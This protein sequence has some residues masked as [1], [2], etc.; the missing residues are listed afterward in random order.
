MISRLVVGHPLPLA[1]GSLKQI[2]IKGQFIVAQE[3]MPLRNIGAKVVGTSTSAISM[4]SSMQA[5]YSSYVTSKFALVKF[6]EVLAAEYPDIHV[7]TFHPGIGTVTLLNLQ[8]IQFG[9]DKCVVETDMFAKSEMSGLPMDTS[10]ISLTPLTHLAVVSTDHMLAALPAHFAVWLVSPEAAFLR[11]KF[12]ST[13]WDVDELKAR[14]K[15]VDSSLLLTSN[16]LGWPFQ[17]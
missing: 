4:D 16:I 5:N 12:V 2:N 9:A 8:T 17:P 11:G 1:N 3:F 15:E 14:A 10:L 7:V 13:N 6:Y